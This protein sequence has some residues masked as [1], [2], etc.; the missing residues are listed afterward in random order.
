M[1]P[2][3]NPPGVGQ[4][5]RGSA[6][7]ASTLRRRRLEEGEGPLY[8]GMMGMGQAP[9]TEEEL[10]AVE[11][12][13]AVDAPAGIGPVVGAVLALAAWV[14]VVGLLPSR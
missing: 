2:S 7:A 12:G 13:E 3:F 11:Q 8:E 9:L 10:L 14:F 6:R 1:Y 4:R 5:G